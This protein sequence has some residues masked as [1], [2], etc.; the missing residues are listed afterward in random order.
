LLSTS[1]IRLGIAHYLGIL[2][3]SHGDPFLVG[4]RQDGA[5]LGHVGEGKASVASMMA[6]ANASS[7]DSPKDPAAE[8]TPASL[9]LSSESDTSV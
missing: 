8:L 4:R 7:K 5:V 6:P 2:L 3:E 9:T 1:S